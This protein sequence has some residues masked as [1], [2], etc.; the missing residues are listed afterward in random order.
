M[1]AWTSRMP[2]PV[3]CMLPIKVAVLPNAGGG[4]GGAVFM[5]VVSNLNTH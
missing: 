4:G 5:W 1:H 2:V 3:L